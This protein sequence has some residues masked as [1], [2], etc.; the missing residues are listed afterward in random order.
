MA[1]AFQVRYD[2][3]NPK[4]LEFDITGR[5]VRGRIDD[6]RLPHPLTEVRAQIHV[7]TTASRSTTCRPA[8]TRRRSR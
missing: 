6:P 1:L 2:P 5:L 7:T 4:P 3:G 8:A